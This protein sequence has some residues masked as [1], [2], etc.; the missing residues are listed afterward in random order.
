[1]TYD[2]YVWM[3]MC[4][5][6]WLGHHRGD[7]RNQP[8]I[9]V[10]GDIRCAKKHRERRLDDRWRQVDNDGYPAIPPAKIMGEL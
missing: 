1:M 3:V 7:Y 9:H 4:G 6:R 5:G 2:G 8:P 10:F